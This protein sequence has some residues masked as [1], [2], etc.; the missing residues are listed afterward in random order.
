MKSRPKMQHLI[1]WDIP[2]RENINTD[3]WGMTYAHLFID[4]IITFC[5]NFEIFWGFSSIWPQFSLK[6]IRFHSESRTEM[7]KFLLCQ[8]PVFSSLAYHFRLLIRPIGV[9]SRLSC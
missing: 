3:G 6:I 5:G 7:L 4:R 9:I 2:N 8:Q 1:V